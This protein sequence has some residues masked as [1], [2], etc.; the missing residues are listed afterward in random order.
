ME[1]RV[2]LLRSSR[3]REVKY[4]HSDGREPLMLFLLKSITLNARSELQ[5][6]GS[7]LDRLH[8]SWRQDDQSKP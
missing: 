5:A 8:R 7:V 3:T 1:K 2:L 6:G 4:D